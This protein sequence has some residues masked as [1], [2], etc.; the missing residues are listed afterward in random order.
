M[1]NTYNFFIS[2]QL[3]LWMGSIRKPIKMRLSNPYDVLTDILR[4]AYMRLLL[5]C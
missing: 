4:V 5:S 2:W 1:C 3:Q